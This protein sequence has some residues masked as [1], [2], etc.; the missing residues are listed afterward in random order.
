MVMV[1]KE[2]KEL[3][4][5]FIGTGEVRGFKFSLF[6]KNDKGYI[7]Q[8]TDGGQPWFEVFERRINQFGGVSYPKAKSFGLWAWSTRQLN[9]ALEKLNLL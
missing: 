9:T 7:Y 6:Q 5:E 3:P 1:S 4:I 2:P 8:V